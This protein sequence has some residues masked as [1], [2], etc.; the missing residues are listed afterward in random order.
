MLYIRMQE[1]EGWDDIL[2]QEQHAEEVKKEYS[3]SG[4]LKYAVNIF[5][6]G[7]TLQSLYRAKVERYVNSTATW[8]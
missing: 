2:C 3:I 4:T 5:M 6:C 7:I 8:M 1:T